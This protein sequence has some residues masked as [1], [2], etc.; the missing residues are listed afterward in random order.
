MA[1]NCWL[2]FRGLVDVI[3]L[4]DFFTYFI[5]VFA[6]THM[7]EVFSFVDVLRF[8]V[9]IGLCVFNWFIKIDALR[10]VKDFAWCTPPV[11][12]CIGRALNMRIGHGLMQALGM[13]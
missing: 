5:C 2:V 6:F 4:N 13:D 11:I 3:L 1:Y 8:G 9:G 10:V 7:P 12:I